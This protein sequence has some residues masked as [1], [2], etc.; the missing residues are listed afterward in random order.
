MNDLKF[1]FRQVRKY[2]GFSTLV[3]LILGI[4]IG[5]NTVV[6]SALEVLVLRSLPVGAPQRMTEGAS[7][8]SPCPD[9]KILLPPSAL[10]D[11]AAARPRIRRADRRP[12][13]DCPT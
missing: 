2:P 13:C 6:F 5:A 8:M 11:T 10:P 3:V 9:R 7:M 4:G 1:A 12:E